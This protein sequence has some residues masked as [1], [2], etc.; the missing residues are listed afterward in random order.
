MKKLQLFY[1][2][3]FNSNRILEYD[4]DIKITPQYARLS[5]ELV[6]LGDNQVLRTIRKITKSEYSEEKIE[7][8]ETEKKNVLK[9]KAT[10]GIEYR[11]IQEV[12]EDIDNLL[13]IPEYV[14]VIIDS[15]TEYKKLI[16]NG[17]KV[18]G[19]KFV[20]LLCGA[21]QA[22]KNTVVF[23]DEAIEKQLKEILY[24]DRKDIEMAHAKYN[25]YF[26]LYSSATFKVSTPRVCVIPDCIVEKPT[27]VDWVEEMDSGDT[28]EEVEKN[29]EYNYW[30]GMG[31]VNPQ[32]SKQWAS[33]MGLDYIPSAF[34]VR[35]SYLKGM[36]CTFDFVDF[37]EKIANKYEAISDVWGNPIQDIRQYDVVLTESM[38]K[39]WKAY[40]SW[41]HYSKCCEKNDIF[42]GIS[43]ASTDKDKDIATLNYQYIQAVNL[44]KANIESLCKKTVDW[45]SDISGLD[46][47]KTILFLYGDNFEKRVKDGKINL[48]TIQNAV[49]ESIILNNDMINDPYIRQSVYNLINKK[50]K[51]S[52]IGKL[53]VDGNYQIMVS[54][55]Y[56]LCEYLFGLEPI[57][58]L[59]NG[60]HFSSYWNKKNVSKVIGMRSPLTWRSEVNELLLQNTDEC[61]YWYKYLSTGIV[62][63]IHGQ[64][65]MLH[66]DSD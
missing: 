65:C 4:S 47:M 52:Y 34:I 59:N 45:F 37:A 38:F 61:N 32:W 25:A 3:K 53:L 46:A 58:L 22:R 17:F 19:R 16:A 20:R 60:Q 63:N 44:D 62:Y 28:I 13:L 29:L 50:I 55:P 48:K 9:G 35:C 36:V 64:D 7:A 51:E 56:A 57:G 10:D 39:L 12:Q 42:W 41:E 8:L 21:G 27:L 54:D 23:C 24:N 2:Y 14:S 66:A 15:K 6:S 26:A 43:R 49:V 5:K 33:E 30:D 31:I 11:K 1:V 40:D 18:N